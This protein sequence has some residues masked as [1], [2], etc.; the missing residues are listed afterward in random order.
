MVGRRCTLLVVGL[1]LL[2]VWLRPSESRE[3]K[4]AAKCAPPSQVYVIRHAEKELDNKED[5]HL[6]TRG[7]GRAAALPSLFVV[8][9]MF[10][11]KPARF[12]SPDFIYAAAASKHSNRPVETVLPLAKALGDM[13]IHQKH[14]DFQPVIDALFNDAKHERKIVMISWRHGKTA[15]LARAIAARAKNADRLKAQIPERWEDAVFDRVWRQ[16]PVRRRTAEA[17]LRRR[18]QVIMV[19]LAEV[20]KAH[21]FLFFF[22]RHR[23][24]LRGECP[25]GQVVR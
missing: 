18:S 16:R 10:P 8:S 4:A 3:P 22:S 24:A 1:G 13:P 12:A 20:E 14:V 9:P 21:A 5:I 25:S 19:L 11:T 17:S 23:A 7:G 15:E 2:L 6:N